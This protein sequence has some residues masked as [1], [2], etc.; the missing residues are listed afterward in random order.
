GERDLGKAG[1]QGRRRRAVPARPLRGPARR[2]GAGGAA[3]RRVHAHLGAEP[4]G[5]RDR[6]RLAP[7]RGPLPRA[8]APPRVLGHR[9]RRAGHPARAVQLAPRARPRPAHRP[10]GVR[11]RAPGRQRSRRRR[12]RRPPQARRRRPRHGRRGRR[13]RRRGAGRRHPGAGRG[14][15]VLGGRPRRRPAGRGD[16][17][18]HRHQ[19]LGRGRRPR[20]APARHAPRVRQGSGLA[21]GGRCRPRR[22]RLGRRVVAAHAEEGDPPRPAR[23][24]ALERRHP[25]RQGRGLHAHAGPR[26]ADRVPAPPPRRRDALR[27]GVRRRDQGDGGP[28]AGREVL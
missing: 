13:P 19:A 6:P 27:V 11:R 23:G 22:R 10:R 3:R 28:L 9:R 5:R 18:A 1:A 4:A 26:A 8:A 17:R 20:G 7:A 2:A 21:A 24:P 14:R 16:D 12:E 25:R 15:A